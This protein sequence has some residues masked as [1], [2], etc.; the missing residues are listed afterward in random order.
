MSIIKALDN[1]AKEELVSFHVPGHKNGRLLNKMSINEKLGYYD[2]T[3]I[4][5]IIYMLQRGLL[6]R[7]RIRPLLFMVH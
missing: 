4:D 5:G 6:K 3:E 2:T 7:H 1:I